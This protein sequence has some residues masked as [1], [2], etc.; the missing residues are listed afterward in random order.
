MA[1]LDP[2]ELR[3]RLDGASVVEVAPLS[4]GSSSLTFAGTRAGQRVVIKVAPPGVDPVAHRD[5]LRQARIIKALGA[6]DVP[7]PTVLWEDAGDP[8]DTPPAI[9]IGMRAAPWPRC[10]DSNRRSSG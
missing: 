2:S 6:S 4:G 7:V 5:V 1:E 9:G 10:T 3:R 8:P